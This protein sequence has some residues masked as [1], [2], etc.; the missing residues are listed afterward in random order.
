MADSILL[1]RDEATAIVTLN[2][3]ERR[4][5]FDLAMWSEL[6]EIMRQVS[7][8]KSLRVVVLRGA[9]GKAFAAGA[10]IAEFEQARFSEAQAIDYA[11][12]MDAA[13]EAVRDCP[14][15]TLAVI[16][17]ACVGGGLELAIQCDLRLC[18]GAAKF[19]IPINRI[20]HCLPYPAMIALVEVVGRATAL[21][22]LL[23]GRIFDADEAYEKGLVSR[24]CADEDFETEVAATIERIAAGAPRAARWHKI[25][26]RRAQDPQSLG[27]ADWNEPYLSCDTEDYHEGVRAFLAKRKPVFQGR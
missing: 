7:T 15:P 22:I 17:G 2:R 16:E 13:T 27:P 26:A 1:T 24:I 21:E 6:G 25:F 8:D 5:A 19:G 20:G 18:N 12:T 23:E 3:P 9:G 10:D 14:H 11:R 4:N